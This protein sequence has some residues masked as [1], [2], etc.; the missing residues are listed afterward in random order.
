MS[1]FLTCLLLL[2]L[3]PYYLSPYFF[4]FL[5]RLH[6]VS[7]PF[8][9]L[10]SFFSLSYLLLNPSFSYFS[11]VF[12]FPLLICWLI[13]SLSFHPSLSIIFPVLFCLLGFL[14]SVYCSVF[15]LFSPSFSYILFCPCFL[16]LLYLH[17][18]SPCFS[19]LCFLY[20][21]LSSCLH[22]YILYLVYRFFFFYFSLFLFETFSINILSP[23]NLFYLRS[24][25]FLP[26]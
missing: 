12:L 5:F 23:C 25:S 24:L 20:F 6:L 3:P 15:L 16:S 9:I 4:R 21:H 18:S 8:H 17:F 19:V 11:A 7:Y 10:S 2:V 1:S 13:F 22:P 14:S 26:F